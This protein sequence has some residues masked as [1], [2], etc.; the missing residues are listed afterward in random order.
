MTASVKAPRYLVYDVLSPINLGMILRVCETFHAPVVLFDPRRVLED[1]G[2]LKTISDFACGALQR[3]P[4]LVCRTD[5]E[6]EPVLTRGRVV[7]TSID[8]GELLPAFAWRDG[9]LVVLG[10]EYDGLPDAVMAQAAAQLQI[11]MPEGF[12]PKPK[13]NSPIDPAR[14]ATVSRDGKPNL[15]VA[16]SCG[17]LA[18]TAWLA[19]NG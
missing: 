16:M 11:P 18:Y 9:D 1:E 12:T 6:L 10:N 19:L 8:D 4:P 5:A 3:V 15:N 14:A 17:I 2:K 13:S 7:A